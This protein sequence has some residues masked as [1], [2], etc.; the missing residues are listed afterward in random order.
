MEE[1]DPKKDPQVLGPFELLAVLGKGG[2]GKVY[3]ARR[4]PLE[5]LGPEMEAGYFLS[6]R[7]E[8]RE[9][10]LAA[11]K[12]ILPEFLE[13]DHQDVS[14]EEKRARF[15]REIRSVQAV[16]SDRVPAFLG[17]DPEAPLPWFASEY[18]HGPDLGSL[19]KY[20]GDHDVK[21][22]VGPYAALGLALVDALRTIHAANLL[23]R[24]LK[25]SNVVLGPS[26]PAILDFGLATLADRRTSQALT[27]AGMG[28]GTPH[29]MPREQ[30]EDLRSVK[31]PGD[32]YSLGATLF[33]VATGGRPP[34]GK[35]GPTNNPPSWTDVGAE[36]IPLLA[37]IIVH[38]PEQRP[39][40]DEVQNDLQ[41]LLITSS[42]TEATAQEQLA[43]LV[44]QAGLA[45][46]LP[47]SASPGA[48]NPVIEQAAQAAVDDGNAPDAPWD[49]LFNQL[50]QL[51]GQGDPQAPAPSDEANTRP[52]PAYTPTVPDPAPAA[53]PEPRQNQSS[54]DTTSYRIAPPLPA[55]ALPPAPVREAPA[56]ALRAARDLRKA[57]A[58]SSQL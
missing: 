22:S 33:Y 40:L 52:L 54:G 48:V 32:V 28:F 36:F 29:Y 27:K 25:P 4:L 39:T 50:L 18:L 56:A 26:G 6:E 15:D 57:Y 11:V 31:E 13:A 41:E 44:V 1:L 46:E 35:W 34:Y 8:A 10:E 16:I 58:H 49:A 37:K 2:M 14:Q 30:A 45:P 17:A 42:L 53:S 20:L 38:V 43:E 21:F 19:V 3:L 24:D 47:A 12:V 23:H 9:N 51:P 7:D 5:R 55:P